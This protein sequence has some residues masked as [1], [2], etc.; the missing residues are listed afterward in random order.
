LT[1]NPILIS[2]AVADEVS[3]IIRNLH[4]PQTRTVGRRQIITGLLK[5]H[6]VSV[7]VTGPGQ[8][9]TAQALTAAIECTRPSLIIQTGC[10]GAYRESRLVI[11]DIAIAS[12]EIDAHLGMECPDSWIAHDELP[13]STL[14][15][16]SRDIKNRYPLCTEL[17]DTTTAELKTR[18][19]KSGIQCLTGPFLTVSTITATDQR[20]AD[21]HQTYGACMENMEGAAAAHVAIHYDIPLLEVRSVSNR[22]G[23]RDTERWNLP[24]SFERIATVIPLIIQNLRMD[25]LM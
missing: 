25:M 19:L 8:A 9:N 16:N 20:A 21:L 15:I 22:V 14:K 23:K 12:E 1:D 18:L 24:L 5:E 2:A 10:G 7:L 4:F 11:G 3:G 17:V 6:S 13:F